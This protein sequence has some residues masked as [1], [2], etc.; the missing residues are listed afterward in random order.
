MEVMKILF[1]TA[2]MLFLSIQNDEWDVLDDWDVKPDTDT[3]EAKKIDTHFMRVFGSDTVWLVRQSFEN[4]K[5][6]RYDKYGKKILVRTYIPIHNMFD[7]NVGGSH[8]YHDSIEHFIVQYY[9]VGNNKSI[10]FCISD[11]TYK[12]NLRKFDSVYQA[13]KGKLFL[14]F[15]ILDATRKNYEFVINSILSKNNKVQS[16]SI[17]SYSTRKVTLHPTKQSVLNNLHI[18]I[19]S[20][21]LDI[22]NIEVKNHLIIHNGVSRISFKN[23]KIDTFSIGGNIS[24]FNDVFTTISKFKYKELSFRCNN[25]TSLPNFRL[26]D[27]V[28]CLWISGQEINTLD[29]NSLPNKIKKIIITMTSTKEIIPLNKV[30]EI[31]SLYITFNELENVDG[32]FVN[33]KGLKYL[34]L[35]DNKIQKKIDISKLNFV[36][37]SIN[38]VGN[39]VVRKKK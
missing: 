20:I 13:T 31:D 23:T 5:E 24:N 21:D 34:S 11:S 37:D 36:P 16:I 18:E 29:L 28:D 27:K 10:Q 8:R 1:L 32:A 2:L 35:V 3:I 9:G 38:Y 39:P 4:G 14:Y 30:K 6:Y 25:F 17:I 12:E 26:F 33:L 15:V 19:D 7:D 22:Q